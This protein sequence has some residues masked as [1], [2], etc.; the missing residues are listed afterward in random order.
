MEVPVSRLS[1]NVPLSSS[2]LQFVVSFHV[3]PSLPVSVAMERLKF[4]VLQQKVCCSSSTAASPHAVVQSSKRSVSTNVVPK[5]KSA[6][7][8]RQVDS[9]QEFVMEN[10]V[11]VHDV[12]ESA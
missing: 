12:M 2:E 3:S 6:R 10:F 11:H 4:I 5:T 7:S 8:T 9:G 1:W